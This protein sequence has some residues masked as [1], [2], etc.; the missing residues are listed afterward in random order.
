VGQRMLQGAVRMMAT[1]FFTAIEAEAKTESHEPPPSHGFFRTA[2]R[3]LSGLLR[4]KFRGT[5]QSVK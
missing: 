3:W 2:L 5:A 4:R 1:Q